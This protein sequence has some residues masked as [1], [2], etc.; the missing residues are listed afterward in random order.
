MTGKYPLILFYV[1]IL[2]YYKKNNIFLKKGRY[3]EMKNNIVDFKTFEAFYKTKN[4]NAT[5]RKIRLNYNY[6]CERPQDYP[7]KEEILK[8]AEEE[9]YWN[10]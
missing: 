6:Y 5:E 3:T 1:K 10:W 8:I 9:A 2:S 4:K 7:N